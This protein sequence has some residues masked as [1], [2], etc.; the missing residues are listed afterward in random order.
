MRI[1]SDVLIGTLDIDVTNQVTGK[2]VK[3]GIVFVPATVTAEF[4]ATTNPD[5][6]YL[7]GQA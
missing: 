7:L 3:L 1:H 4:K 6:C 5:V 2:R